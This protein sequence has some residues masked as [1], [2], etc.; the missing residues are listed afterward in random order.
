MNI[1]GNTF[2][3][4]GGASGLGEAVARK[5]IA[6]DGRVLIADLNVEVG[7]ALAKEL[8]ENA[9]FAATDVSSES[10]VK[11]SIDLAVSS[12]G[13]IQGVVHCAGIAP[14]QKILGKEGVHA[15]DLF[16]NV[17]QVN[18]LG[19]FNVLRLSAK[20]I[21]AN[22][23]SVTGERGVIVQTASVAALEGQ[24]GQAAYAA[25]KGGVVAMTLPIAREL[26]RYG[27][28]VMTV[29][30]GIMETPMLRGL[31]QNVQ[32]SL[33]KM[34]PFP[35]RLGKPEEF[36]LLVAHILENPYL[37]GEVIRLDGAIRMGAS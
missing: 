31:P 29:A 23:P 22:A 15:L 35:V 3:V 2:L 18:L 20:A 25:S 30:P 5:I 36:A 21:T 1:S 37:N 27:I 11:T 34:V 12:F 24:I 9:C 8:G 19:T 13:S 28:R 7:A 4:T 32:D 14:A 26:A 6:S 17:I 10:S 16:A 33:G